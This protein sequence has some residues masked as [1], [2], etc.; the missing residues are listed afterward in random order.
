MKNYIGMFVGPYQIKTC[1]ES[2]RKTYFNE[3]VLEIVLSDKET[4]E[5]PTHIAE[6]V[7]TKVKSDLTK[8]RDATGD[9]TA[10]QIL[11][12][13]LNNEIKAEDVGYVLERVNE[14]ILQRLR[15]ASDILFG[16]PRH[17]LTLWDVQG[18]LQKNGDKA[19]NTNG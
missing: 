1:K 13:M 12:I 5:L 16:K 7:V 19:K 14:T 10:S 3:L 9:Y 11:T 8:Q 6:Q 2:K 17:K 4:V 18:V 15:D